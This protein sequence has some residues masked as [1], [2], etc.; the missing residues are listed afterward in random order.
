MS[1]ELRNKKRKSLLKKL[2]II[3]FLLFTIHYSLFTVHCYSEVVDRVVAIVDDEAIMLSELNSAY[4]RAFSPQ[5]ESA[6][7]ENSKIDITQEEVLN[8]LIN[9]VLLLK[10]A[11][12]FSHSIQTRNDYDENTLIKEYIEKQ[13][14]TFIRI[15]FEEIEQFYEKNKEKFG[16][17]DFYDVRD[18]IEELLIE[19]ELN[20]RLIRHIEE[21]RKNA[22]IKI[23]LMEGNY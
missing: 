1:Y 20:K 9:R 19:K 6:E 3:F 22:Y 15:P 21:L 10:Q 8:G 2:F 11:K 17:K 7:A 12:K 4:Q 18:E 16:S 13:L 5:G 23:Q 14:K